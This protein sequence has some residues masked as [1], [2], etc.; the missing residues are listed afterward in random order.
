VFG[1]GFLY[2]RGEKMSKSIGNVVDPFALANNFVDQLR[3]FLLREVLFGQDG[4][5]SRW[6]SCVQTLISLSI[7][8]SCPA[9][10]VHDCQELR[11]SVRRGE[12]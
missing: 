1:H 11:W 9:L 2:S 3:Y 10:T 7:S 12:R 8:Q 5:Y 6:L 4:N